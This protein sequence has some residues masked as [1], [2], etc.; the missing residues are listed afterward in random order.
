MGGLAPT[1]FIRARESTV[2]QLPKRLGNTSLPVLAASLK[3]PA[4]RSAS[5]SVESYLGT[6]WGLTHTFTPGPAKC[7]TE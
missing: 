2:W 3:A 5:L 7:V 6:R 1:T 4:G